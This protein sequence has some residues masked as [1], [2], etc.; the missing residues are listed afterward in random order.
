MIFFKIAFFLLGEKN[1]HSNLSISRSQILLSRLLID[2]LFPL[3]PL[4]NMPP[5]LHRSHP[6]LLIYPIG[7]ILFGVS[8]SF[9]LF[10]FRESI[11]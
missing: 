11:V 3:I 6:F 1:F 9:A 10:Y 4:A 5:T 8:I 2:S 7:T